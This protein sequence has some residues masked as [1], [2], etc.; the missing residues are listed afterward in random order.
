MVAKNLLEDFEVSENCCS[1]RYVLLN[2]YHHLQL[3]VNW[4]SEYL[5]R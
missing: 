2:T 5:L 1:L 4:F 3:Y